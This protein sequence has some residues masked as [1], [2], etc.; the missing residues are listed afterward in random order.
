MREITQ[1][2]LDL[3]ETSME[4]MAKFDENLA[5]PY[6]PCPLDALGSKR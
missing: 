5:A 4:I 1:A 3:R 6:L 2:C